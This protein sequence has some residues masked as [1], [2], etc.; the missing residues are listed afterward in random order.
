M[1]LSKLTDF[2]IFGTLNPEKTWHEHVTDF[3]TSPVRCSHFT[4]GNPKKSFFNIIIHIRQIIYVTSKENKYQQLYCRFSC[5]LTVVASYYLHS[6]STASGARYRRSAC[7]DMDV[8]RLAAVAC[9]DM[10]WISAQR[11]VLCD[12]SVS[13]K[14]E[15][16]VN[17]EHGHSEH[18]LWHCLPDI[19]VATHPNQF[20]QS[21]R[22]Q[23]TTGCLQSLQRLKERN[24]PSVRWKSFAVHKLAW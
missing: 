11:G 6:R 15:A 20:F 24:K 10:G 5:L 8:L 21:Y 19:P 7:I 9:C 16:C 13:K 2:N 14:I 12:W 18:L 3:C 4:L 22:R 17:A 23:P 1:T